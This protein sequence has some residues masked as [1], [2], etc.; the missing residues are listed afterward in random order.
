MFHC[1][2]LISI[3]QAAAMARNG[4]VWAVATEGM[5]MNKI[6]EA[7]IHLSFITP[8]SPKLI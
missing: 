3:A 7:I 2:I 4:L 1:H 5:N 8:H 6:E